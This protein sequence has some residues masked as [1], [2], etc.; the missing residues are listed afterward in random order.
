MVRRACPSRVCVCVCISSNCTAAAG[1]AR[2]LSRVRVERERLRPTLFPPPTRA[3]RS[4]SYDTDQDR[5]WGQRSP[6]LPAAPLS[7]LMELLL[8]FTVAHTH[9]DAAP[10]AYGIPLRF[11]VC[12]CVLL[13]CLFTSLFAA[14]LQS[15]GAPLS[16][17]QRGNGE[18]DSDG[19]TPPPLAVSSPLPLFAYHFNLE[20]HR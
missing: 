3:P 15:G 6:R 13:L 14:T 8:T 10:S 4:V 11:R 18:G 2:T 17:T 7:P 16:V 12:A 9:A 20:F 5:A 19:S 1:G